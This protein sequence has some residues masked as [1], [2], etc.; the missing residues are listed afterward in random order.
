MIIGLVGL[1]GSGKSTAADRLVNYHGFREVSFASALKDSVSVLFDWPRHMLEGNSAESR[2]WRD[3]PDEFWTRELSWNDGFTPRKALQYFATN[4]VR[5]H[6]HNDFWVLRLKKTLSSVHGN[7]VVSDCRFPNEIQMIRSL[8]GEVWEIQ[9]GELPGWFLDARNF[10]KTHPN[11]SVAQIKFME[12]KLGVHS[13]EWIRAATAV[14]RIIYNN[15]LDAFTYSVDEI[16]I[17]LLNDDS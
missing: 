7:I 3:Q 15:E 11:P 2:A 13:S 14:D 4:V 17:K 5:N 9:R 6:V 8:G 10:L 16:V 1:I 12:S